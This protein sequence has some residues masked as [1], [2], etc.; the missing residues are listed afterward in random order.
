MEEEL[1]QTSK[2]EIQ[3]K[4]SQC[5][6][7]NVPNLRIV[8]P[9]FFFDSVVVSSVQSTDSSSAKSPDRIYILRRGGVEGICLYDTAGD[10]QDDCHHPQLSIFP[11]AADHWLENEIRSDFSNFQEI[12]QTDQQ[13]KE[14]KISGGKCK[15][16]AD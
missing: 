2:Q 13:V 11:S 16:D 10:T 14:R 5:P 1:G 7:A 4:T 15:F 12:L 9:S 6:P 8:L 3:Q